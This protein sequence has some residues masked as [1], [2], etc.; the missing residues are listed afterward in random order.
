MGDL[1]GMLDRQPGR[2]S[3]SDH[4]QHIGGVD[5]VGRQDAPQQFVA[6]D[7][8][9]EIHRVFHADSALV[10]GQLSLQAPLQGRLGQRDLVQQGAETGVRIRLQ[11]LIRGVVLRVGRKAHLCQFLIQVETRLHPRG[12]GLSAR[13]RA[14]HRDAALAQIVLGHAQV[15]AADVHPWGQTLAFEFPP[16]QSLIDA[17]GRQD[18]RH[19]RTLC[20]EEGGQIVQFAI[21]QRDQMQVTVKRGIGEGFA[22]RGGVDPNVDRVGKKHG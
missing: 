1:L 22:S 17:R 19:R 18:G 14:R 13:G 9:E 11:H 2:V 21:C 6:R 15:R 5:Q 10:Q 8:L 12:T 4:V 3:R 16:H 20:A 7:L